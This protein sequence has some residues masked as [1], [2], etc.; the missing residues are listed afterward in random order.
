MSFMNDL[1][2]TE[3]QENKNTE[4]KISIDL[5]KKVEISVGEILKVEKVEDADKLLKLKVD[6]GNHQRQIISGI[7]EYF[8]DFDS[9][10]GLK[11]PFV[12]NLEPRTIRGLESNGM[13][14]AAKDDDGNFSLL[15]IDQNIKNG[16]RIS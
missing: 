6:F 1:I 12:T 3:V 5:F 13:I 14:M 16:T 9:L 4:N 8:P 2:N 15:K 10:I 11:C 7:A